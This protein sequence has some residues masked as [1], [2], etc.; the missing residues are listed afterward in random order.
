MTELKE[1]LGDDLPL[2]GQQMSSNHW[3]IHGDHTET[4]MPLFASD[5][6]L[7]TMLPSFWNLF[8]LH[9]PNG[10]VHSGGSMPGTPGV[11]I[12]R[13]ER[14]AWAFTTSRSDSSDVF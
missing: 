1:M 14:I 7:G 11:D 2:W 6:H 10:D 3:V 5:P 4:G 8:V 13:T 12:G 9:L